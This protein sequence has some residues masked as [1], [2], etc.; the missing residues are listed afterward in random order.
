MKN[1]RTGILYMTSAILLLLCVS[2]SEQTRN[3]ENHPYF[4]KALRL[5]SEGNYEESVKYFEK[6]LRIYPE[7]AK[8][9]YEL[10]VVYDEGLNMPLDAIYHYNQYL[11]FSPDSQDAEYIKDSLAGAEKKF[12]LKMKKK[13][14]GISDEE[15][16]VRKKNTTAVQQ[17]PE[18]PRTLV[19]VQT[20]AAP[21]ALAAAEKTTA[22]SKKFP[23]FYTVEK[24]DT[25]AKISGKVY[26]NT[27]YYKAIY[28]AN[29]EALSSETSIRIGQRLRI[30]PPETNN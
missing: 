7:S 10:A 8:A 28:E 14:T 5:N 12:Y 13:Y 29:R 25:L 1:Y 9:H 6:Y 27:K 11:K 24:G 4:S 19:P 21:A 26:G 17:A 3:E 20:P 16:N 23:E 22:Q 15:L 30:P 2:C 18:T